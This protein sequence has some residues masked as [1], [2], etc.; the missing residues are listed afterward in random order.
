[1][2]GSGT[3]IVAPGAGAATRLAV[4]MRARL[5]DTRALAAGSAVSGVLAYVFFVLATR[6][7]GP[8]AA[9]PVSVLWTY[10]SFAAA[11]LTFPVQHWIARSVAARGD[12]GAVHAAMPRVAGFVAAAAVV[13][14]GLAWLGRSSLFHSDAIWFPLLVLCVTLGSGFVGVVRGGLTARQRFTSVAWALVAE[15]GLRCVAAG[16]LVVIGAHSSVSFGVCLA[17]GALVGFLWPS[18]FRFA[19]GGPDEEHDSPLAFVGGA[20][21]GQL[22]GQAVLTGGPVLLALTGGTPTEITALFAALALYRA[23]YTLALGLVAQ[24]TGRLTRLVVDREHGALRRVRLT[25]LGA[26]V[27]LVSSA[28]LIGAVVGP[29]L[30]PLVFGHRVQLEWFPSMLVAIGSALALANLVTTISIMA[31]SRSHAIAL[32]WGLALVGG[33]AAFLTITSQPLDRTCWT[34]LVA[35][36]VAFVALVLAELRGATRLA[37]QTL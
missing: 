6:A 30:L 27:V 29:W 19:P 37:P 11:A 14:G 16:L 13:S 31:Q 4:A 35:E 34:F 2:A 22:I 28:A 17:I 32:A 1:V 9:A 24:L 15:N 20:A 23:P 25:I 18:A 21:G 33:L 7:L 36:A 26:T 3:A 8:T 12:E 10:W 5:R